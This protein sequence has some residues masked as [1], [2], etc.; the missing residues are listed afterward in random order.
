MV[1]QPDYATLAELKSFMRISDTVDDAELAFAISAASRSIDAHTDRQFGQ[2]ASP[3]LWSYLAWPDL[4]RNRWVVEIDD[5]MTAV[6]LI[7][8]VPTVGTTTEFTKEPLNGAGKARPWTRIVFNRLA[9][10]HPVCTDNYAVNVTGQFGWTVVPVAVKEACLLQASRFAKRR[11][12]PFG[13]A[14]SPDLGSEIRLL[15]KVDPDVAVILTPY[16]RI[17]RVG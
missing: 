8:E 14:G 2:L 3:I 15:A 12:A 4:H 16:R 5:L 9:S 1:W 11:D 6:G 17:G 7:V 13:V 10:V